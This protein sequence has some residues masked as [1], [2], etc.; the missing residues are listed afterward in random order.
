M[1]KK[2]FFI[3][4]LFSNTLFSQSRDKINKITKEV[5]QNNWERFFDM[6]SIPNDGYDSPNIERNIKTW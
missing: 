6:L 4:L 2:I 1:S 3:I 5:I